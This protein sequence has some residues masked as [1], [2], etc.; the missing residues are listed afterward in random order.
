MD[1]YDHV[2]GVRSNN[3]C[4][5]GTLQ[6][7]LPTTITLWLYIGHEHQAHID[8]V[9]DIEK[10]SSRHMSHRHSVSIRYYRLGNRRWE[11]VAIHAVIAEVTDS[12]SFEMQH[13]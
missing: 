10:A 3:I 4:A 9:V 8:R 1:F 11:A 2:A 6:Q 7:Q 5:K 13:N 12:V